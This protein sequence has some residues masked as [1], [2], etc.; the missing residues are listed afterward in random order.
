MPLKNY[1]TAAIV[2]ILAVAFTGTT[3]AQDENQFAY[4]I[5]A[6]AGGRIDISREVGSYCITGAVK[7]ETIRGEGSFTKHEVV[8][9]APG[10]MAIDHTIDWSTFEDAIRNLTVTSA[11]R[12]CAPGI[13][14]AANAYSNGDYAIQAGDYISPYHPLVRSGDVGA[15]SITSQVWE[16]Q[17][18]PNPGHTAFIYSEFEAGHSGNVFYDRDDVPEAIEDRSGWFAQTDPHWPGRDVFHYGP[19]FRGNYFDIWQHLYTSD[20]TTRRNTSISSPFSHGR[21]VSDWT[22]DGMTEAWEELEMDNLPTGRL[23]V[24]VSWWYLF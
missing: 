12:L 11:I 21:I 24:P 6:R 18:S 17:V 14:T 16:V 5:D 19:Y 3:L 1:I 23:A 20:G 15:S 10:A 7:R 2:F 13:S 4:Q 9:F 8:R 22:V